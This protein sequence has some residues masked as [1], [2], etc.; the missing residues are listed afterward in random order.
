ML[1]SFAAENVEAADRL[2]Q[3]SVRRLEIITTWQLDGAHRQLT[4]ALAEVTC[5]S[6]TGNCRSDTEAAIR[7]LLRLPRGHPDEVT[8]SEIG[9]LRFVLADADEEAPAVPQVQAAPEAE[10]ERPEEVVQRI[11]PSLNAVLGFGEG[12]VIK[13]SDPR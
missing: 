6:S 9:G 10:P 3:G 5:F 12:R 13:A 11:M 4:A 2:Q 1:L 8:V 7:R